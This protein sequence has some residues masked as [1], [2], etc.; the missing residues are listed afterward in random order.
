MLT[1]VN[2]KGIKCYTSILFFFYD[3]TNV[4]SGRES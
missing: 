2:F 1:V 4:N 3:H